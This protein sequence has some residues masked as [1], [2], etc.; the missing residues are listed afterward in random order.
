[1]LQPAPRS[2]LILYFTLALAL[3]VWY[4]PDAAALVEALKGTSRSV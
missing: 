4:R 2:A 1:V 3:W